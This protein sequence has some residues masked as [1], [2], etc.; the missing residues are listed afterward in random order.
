[1]EAD[2]EFVVTGGTEEDDEQTLEE[3]ER[4]E[5]ES[6]PRNEIDNLQKEGKLAY[7]VFFWWWWCLCSGHLLVP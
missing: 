4:L 5:G 3:E 6:D 1:M 2:E 7:S